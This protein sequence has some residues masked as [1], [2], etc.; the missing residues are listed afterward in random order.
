[1]DTILG[2]SFGFCTAF[3]Q[4][5]SYIFSGFAVR[6][7]GNL[8]T[9]GILARTHI[10]IA[11]VSLLT[12]PFFWT[13]KLLGNAA[14]YLP[15]TIMGILS[16]L[17]GQ[18]GLLLA[19]RKIDASRVVPFLGIK[20]VFLALIN[21]LILRNASYSLIQWIALAMTIFSAFLINKAGKS[22]SWQSIFWLCITCAG[23]S[24]SDTYMHRLMAA[25]QSIGI[26]HTLHC[27][28]LSSILANTT[29]GMAALVV[30]L[31]VPKANDWQ[32]WRC[33]SPFGFFWMVAMMF[34][35]A[36]FAK[37]GTVNGNIIQNTRGI[38]VILLSLLLVK[39]GFTELEEKVSAIIVIKRLLAAAIML[40]AIIMFNVS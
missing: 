13:P 16:Y 3:S 37:I 30:M 38:I 32:V 17:I 29:A 28:M 14:V 36:C 24:V 7:H 40:A 8:G 15:P 18:S 12:L 25:L 31:F 6:R 2:I 39:L 22:M 10:F 20:L 33:T 26:D 4:A 1:M 11:I 9:I 21:C 23:Y 27:A 34:L 5:L 35:Y 19:Q